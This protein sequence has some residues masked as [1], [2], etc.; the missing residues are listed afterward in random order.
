MLLPGEIEYYK[1]YMFA[2]RLGIRPWEIDLLPIEDQNALWTLMQ[3]DMKYG[4]NKKRDL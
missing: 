2:T 3:Y 1:Q 4:G